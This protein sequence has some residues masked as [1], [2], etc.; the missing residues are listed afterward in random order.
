MSEKINIDEIAIKP[1]TTALKQVK[2]KTARKPRDPNKKPVTRKLKSSIKPKIVIVDDSS[3]DKP[4]PI[5]NFSI[6]DNNPVEE[7]ELKKEFGEYNCE[8]S[9]NLFSKDC[10]NFLLK[11]ELIENELLKE[12]TSNNLY[13]TLND[14]NFN[15]KISQKKEFNDTKYDG[16]IYELEK[17]ADILANAEFELAPYQSFVRNF[18]SFQTPYNSLLLYHQLGTGKTCSSI[19]IC[20]EMRQ[21][22]K[23]MGISKRI[24]IV[25]SPNVQDNFRLQL[26]D[27][28]KL[29]LVDGL[30]NMRACIGN[31]LI[32]EVNPT[33]MKGI[34][35]EK[36][37][38]Q[39]KS[40]INT[41]YLFLGYI[42][43]ANYIEKTTQLKGD[44]KTE[45]ERNSRIT[46]NIQNEFDSRLIVIDEVH[47]IRITEDN[48]NKK[49]AEQ[50]MKL[51]KTAKN[52]RLVLLSATPMYNSQLEIIWLLNLMNINDRR[53]TVQISDIFDKNGDFKK[54]E[55]G[56]EIGKELLIHKATGYISFVRGENPYTFPFRVFPSLFSPQNTF[57]NKESKISYPSFQM[58]GK[59]I[60]PESK[61]KYLDIYLTKIGSY[62]SLVYK[63]I[64]D[65]LRKKKITITTK[66]GVIREMP[67]FDNMNS[68]GYTLLQLPLEALNISYPIE[69]IEKA[70]EFVVPIEDFSDL[71]SNNTNNNNNT[72]SSGGK[73]HSNS[74]K[75]LSSTS[76]KSLSSFDSSSSSLPSS[77]SSSSSTETSDI[78]QTS[79]DSSSSLLSSSSSLG[80][81]I[82]PHE[83]TGKKGLERVMD[84]VDSKNPPER[85][86]F[87]YKES[88]LS[89]YGK[90]FSNSE[91]GKYSAKI[92]NVCD[93]IVSEKGIVSDGIIL[94]YS[95]YIDGGLFPM[96]LALEEMGFTR[97]GTAPSLFKNKPCEPVDSRT[98][99][100]KK[101]TGDFLPAKYILITGDPRISPNNNNEIK[102][103]TNDNNK[104]GNIIKV[105]LISNAGSEGLDFKFLRQIHIF[106][107]WYNMNRSEQIIGRGVRNFS[108][109]DLPFE[110]RNVEIFMY[111]T[112]LENNTEESADLYVYRVAEYKATQIGKVSR[113]LKETAVDCI[114]NH[115]QTNFTQ[116]N[117]TST[118]E[119]KVKQVLSNGMIIEDFL[120]GDAPYSSACDYMENCEY[121]CYPN[122][123]IKEEDITQYTY[124]ESFIV[125]NSE[126]I[127]K[128]IK[129]LMKEKYFY[130]KNDFIQK[131]NIPKPYP[132]VQIYAALSQII[133]DNTEYIVDKYGRTGYLI[134][135]GEYYLFQ[136][137]ELN[138]QNSSL[139]DRSVPIDFKHN[140]IEFNVKPN[141][142]KKQTSDARISDKEKEKEKERQKGEQEEEE[143][144]REGQDEG[145]LV[146]KTK[147]GVGNSEIIKKIKEN[148]ELVRT[149][150]K[151]GAKID[152]GDDNWY[153]HCGYT[154]RKLLEENAIP[155]ED[156][157]IFVIEHMI[158]FLKFEEKLELLNYL[159]SL[160]S[161][162]KGSIENTIKTYFETFLLNNKR[163]TGLI[164]YSKEKEVI[165]LKKNKWV[166]GQP[167]DKREILELEEALKEKLTNGNTFNEV[168]GFIDFEQKKRYLVFKTKKTAVKRNVGHRCDE[169]VKFKKIQTLNEILGEEKYNKE[170]TKGMLQSEICSL[171]EFYLRYF[172][173]SNKDSKIWFLN[174]EVAKM[175]GL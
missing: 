115:D 157:F 141:I 144:R 160:D 5:E 131:I 156:L 1:T 123:E 92:K 171:Q 34:K 54:D 95:Q 111:G 152:R 159:Y 121:K 74:S 30:W 158:D 8:Q 86:S 61:L 172:N 28:R 40:L 138:N 134:N 23:Q 76:D 27:E 39:V 85:G 33:N 90:I 46:R 20:E 110:K 68:F 127:I 69:N 132:L 97:Y 136:P 67:T 143:K 129:Q 175:F 9:E 155:E 71:E 100:P 25:A 94:I 146:F 44:Y 6:T 96:V 164:L 125:M 135:I 117:M 70:V 14:P 133:D 51:V 37:I 52:M 104:D 114:I 17:R 42:E 57:I 109:K 80:F 50:L 140:M 113:C 169:A 91:I 29:Q 126:K 63:Y 36:I 154:I 65:N 93:S 120:V 66:T 137:N 49:V 163:I 19:G 139:F 147:L 98:M 3:S 170:N 87:S 13:P 103:L 60:D 35:K 64:I 107:P 78:S 145:Q 11:K 142:S 101:S 151:P 99:K 43:F 148:Y 31:T 48:E 118:L 56:V 82:D 124:N 168:I 173:K 122:K 32:K 53:A 47:N 18:L 83:L 128:K 55:N 108:H 89:K 12:D 41:S 161:I 15:I 45:K 165:I 24:I 77:S 73:K 58:N 2:P 16:T 167:E 79:F 153:K 7:S 59:T 88:T 38:S 119:Q 116:E 166:I 149:F 84:F 21:Y 105:V 130:K 26:F 102:A 75:S 81:V 162:E 112:I 22:L 106:E 62:Q 150:Y 10:N 174:F 72:N 4:E